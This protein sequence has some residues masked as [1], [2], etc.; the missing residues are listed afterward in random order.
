[1]PARKI[2]AVTLQDVCWPTLEDAPQQRLASPGVPTANSAQRRARCGFAVVA[3]GARFLESKRRV[4]V[5]P[6]SSR[7]RRA[8]RVIDAGQLVLASTTLSAL[9]I[10][11]SRMAVSPRSLAAQTLAVKKHFVVES[12]TLAQRGQLF[13]VG[14]RGARSLEC[15]SSRGPPRHRQRQIVSGHHVSAANDRRRQ[16]TVQEPKEIQQVPF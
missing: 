4:V 7:T 10:T 9:K 6:G 13:G 3:A 11:R 8:D 5:L 1:M 16:T 15:R 14:A 12:Q 2:S